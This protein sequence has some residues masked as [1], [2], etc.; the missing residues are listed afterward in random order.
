MKNDKVG[1][2]FGTQCIGR[3]IQNALVYTIADIAIS[4][5]CTF[6]IQRVVCFA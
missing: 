2:F 3:P 1:C 4:L 5:Q 6:H